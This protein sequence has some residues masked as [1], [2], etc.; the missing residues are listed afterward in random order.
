MFRCSD[1]NLDVQLLFANLPLKWSYCLWDSIRGFLKCPVDV[2]I[3]RYL[4]SHILILHLFY[5]VCLNFLGCPWFLCSK[6]ETRCD[7]FH[8]FMG[9]YR[10]GPVLPIL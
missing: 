6:S 7:R 2:N 5:N 4:N 9:P 8:F 10:F 1:I 3:Y